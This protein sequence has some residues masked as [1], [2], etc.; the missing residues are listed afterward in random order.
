MDAKQAK[1]EDLRKAFVA[2]RKVNGMEET[3]KVLKPFGAVRDGEFDLDFIPESKWSLAIRALKF[4]DWTEAGVQEEP[5][6]LADL[7]STAIYA[8]W[9]AVGKR[10]DQ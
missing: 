3:Q 10:H 6:T 9:N 8:R 2:H 1:R 4:G 7:D 5:R